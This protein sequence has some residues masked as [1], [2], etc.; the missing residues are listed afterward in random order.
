MTWS[1][2][3]F[4]CFAVGSLWAFATLLLGG[5]HLGHGHASHAH[6]LH[7]VKAHGGSS[8]SSAHWTHV[9]NPS[10][11]AVFVAWFGGVGYLLTRYTGM[12]LWLNVL[13]SVAVGVCGA[14]ILAAFLRFLQSREGYL[15]PLDYEMVGIL[16]QVSSPIRAAGVGEILYVREGARRCLPA[17]SEDG[18]PIGRGQ[19]V[20]VTRY[21]QGTAYV[22]TW[23]A[24]TQ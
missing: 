1:E 18:E 24:M 19:E 6:G 8:H 15:D 17:R 9:V 2:F 12:L 13:L 3:Y 23:D 14:W 4:L 16:G 10:I 5:L 21:V 11:L 7:G 22:R 20:I